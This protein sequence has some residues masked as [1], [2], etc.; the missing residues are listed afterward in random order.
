MPQ[1]PCHGWWFCF[2]FKEDFLGLIGLLTKSN[3]N[4]NKLCTKFKRELK[5]DP[6]IKWIYHSFK[7]IKT[8]CL[9]NSYILTLNDYFH[10]EIDWVVP[11]NEL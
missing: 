5:Y 3:K 7:T 1:S 6:K 9:P 8:E 11:R 4:L 10:F 2:Q